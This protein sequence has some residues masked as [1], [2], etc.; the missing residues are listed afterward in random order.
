MSAG[1]LGDAMDMNNLMLSLLFG[2]VGF[3]FLMFGMKMTK[4]VPIICGLAL[5]VVPYFLSNAWVL[6]VACLGLCVVPF[7]LRE[8]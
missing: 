7:V 2:S 6:S 8:A 4:L 3:G 5:M 1:S